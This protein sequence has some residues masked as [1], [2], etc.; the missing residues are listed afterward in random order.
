MSLRVF[1]CV[2]D[3]SDFLFCFTLS[4]FLRLLFLAVQDDGQMNMSFLSF[5]PF[6]SDFFSIRI[7]LLLLLLD[8]ERKRER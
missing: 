2:P 8:K 7:L 1:F 3:V 5:R 4:F 6:S